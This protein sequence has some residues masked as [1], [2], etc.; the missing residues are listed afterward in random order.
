LNSSANGSTYEQAMRRANDAVAQGRL[1]LALSAAE[2]ALGEKTDSVDA[3]NLRGALLARLGRTDDA[4][5][6]F[7]RAL[8]ISPEAVECHYNRGNLLLLTARHPEAID[9][10]DRALTVKPDMVEALYNRGLALAALRRF[11]EAIASYSAAI[12]RRPNFADAYA[13]RAVA[14]SE[15][16]KLEFSLADFSQATALAPANGTFRWNR[17]IS[18][19]LGGD[20]EHGLIEFEWRPE[21]SLG[22]APRPAL[23]FWRG[24]PLANR[25]ILLRAEQGLGDTIQ[26]CRYAPLVAEKG[27]RVILDVQPQLKPLLVK[28]DGVSHVVARGETVPSYDCYCPLLSLPLLFR[29]RIENVPARIPYVVAQ[30]SRVRA[31]REQLAFKNSELNVG[32][33][34]AGK[35]GAIDSGRSIPLRCFAALSGVPNVRLIS[36]QKEVGID[37]IGQL[38]DGMRVETLDTFDGPGEAFL[39]TVAVMESLDLIVASDSAIAHLAGALGRP[40]WLALKLAPDWRWL[41]KRSDSPWYPTMR[42]FRQERLDDWMEVFAAIA[43]E[44]QTLAQKKTGVGA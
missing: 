5:E 31:W 6:S 22:S 19:L 30:S 39:D 40:V 37:Q 17:A 10:F 2:L 36:L 38:A 28:L 1:D 26:F 16:A 34:W 23:P 21:G 41:L 24:E 13:S 11:E 9:A 4:F 42:L 3:L 33:A 8:A 14:Y 20:F 43:R 25:T 15:T 35:P 18:M 7:D 32:I 29:T 44:L 27:A 12:V